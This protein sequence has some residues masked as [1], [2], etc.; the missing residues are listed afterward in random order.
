MLPVFATP[1]ALLGLLALPVLVGIYWL[2]NRF[3]P[4]PVSSLMLWADQRES[5]AGGPRLRRP[6]TPL[7]FFLELLAILLL[8]LAATGPSAD[9][10]MSAR[11]LVVV[12]DDSFSMRAGGNESPRRQALK[13][14]MK[15]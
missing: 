13:A 1:W 4:L 14:L 8:V 5:R 3:R 10:T 7:L 6:Q 9:T 2:R 11:P 12:L 15:L